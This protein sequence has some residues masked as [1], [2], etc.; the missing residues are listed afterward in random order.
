MPEQAVMVVWV[1]A[2]G[3]LGGVLVASL[4]AVWAGYVLALHCC[5]TGW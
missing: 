3:A 4:L 5:R 2:G 1:A